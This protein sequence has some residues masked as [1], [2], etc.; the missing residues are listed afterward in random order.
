MAKTGACGRDGGS[1]LGLRI[2]EKGNCSDVKK[3]SFE[4]KTQFQGSA[5]FKQTLRN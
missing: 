3:L 2:K 5:I 4:E 1:G